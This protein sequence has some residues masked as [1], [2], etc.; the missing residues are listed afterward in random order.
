MP[1]RAAK[2]ALAPQPIASLFDA[3]RAVSATSV[4]VVSCP[5]L[6]C[7]DGAT[8]FQQTPGSA[9]RGSVP[10]TAP[11]AAASRR[12]PSSSPTCGA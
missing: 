1:A 8:P 5:R 3:R 2:P 10:V 9:R 11:S 4:M 6:P 7:R 12:N